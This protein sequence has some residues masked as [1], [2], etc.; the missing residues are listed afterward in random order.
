MDQLQA[1]YFLV[2]A[3]NGMQGDIVEIGTWCGRS[4]LAMGAAVRHLSDCTVYCV[5]LFPRLDDWRENP[6]GSNS[7]TVNINGKQFSGYQQQTVWNQ[8]FKEQ[9]IPTYEKANDL[10]DFLKQRIRDAGFENFVVPY[11]GDLTS[12]LESQPPDFRCRLAFLDGDHGYEAV[13]RDIEAISERLVAG[14]WLCFDDAFTT[15]EGVDRAIAGLVLRNPM[16]DMKEQLTR[17]LFAARRRLY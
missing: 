3:S 14:G 2:L 11:R 16:Y 4:A 6:D 7:F 12:F 8:A 15:Y 5:D 10:L 13:C 17:K 1:L 9:V